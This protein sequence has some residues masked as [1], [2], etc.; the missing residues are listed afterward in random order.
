MNTSNFP[1]LLQRFFT[2]WLITQQGASPH[3]VAG[4]RD[5]FRLLLQFAKNRLVGFRP[6]C[7]SRNSTR[8]S[9]RNSS[10]TWNTS[11]ATGRV[12]ETIAS[13]RFTP[14]SATFRSLS[15]RSACSASAFLPFLRSASREDRWSSS[16]RKKQPHWCRRR[17]PRHGLAPGSCAPPGAVQTGMRN[18]EL[19]SLRCQD[20]ELRVGA[21]IRCFGKGRKMRCTPLKPE[22]VSVLR[23]GCR[24][25]AEGQRT[26]SSPV[27]AVDNLAPMPSSASS[28]DTWLAPAIH[29]LL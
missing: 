27:H 8:S 23:A 2:D 6:R 14:S 21:H 7:V 3:T 13:R 17:M 16:P 29:V 24:N 4:Y 28:H 22:V 11:E 10:N 12:H 26:R 1:A 18:S 15:R 5:T 9:W 19:T 20:V 25:A